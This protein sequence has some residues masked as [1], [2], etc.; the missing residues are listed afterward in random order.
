MRSFTTSLGL[1]LL[2][3]LAATGA[4]AASPTPPLTSGAAAQMLYAQWFVPQSAKARTSAEQLHQQLQQYCAGRSSLEQARAQF[5]QASQDWERLSA[6]AM[7]P[8]IERRTARMV[9]FQP[10]RPQ[11]LQ[12]ALRKAPKNLA[13]METI[14]APAKGFPVAEH[15]LWTDVAQA[16]T[17]ACHYATLVAADL[18]QELRALHQANLAASQFTQLDFD[19]TA[20][21]INQWVGGLERLRWQ[22]MEKPLRSASSSKPAQLTR[23]ASQGTLASW[24]AQ[25]SALRRLT[26]GEG[27]QPEQVS[28]ARLVEVQGWEHLAQEVRE[29]TQKVDS[30]MQAIQAPDLDNITATSKALNQLKHLVENDVAMALDIS[31]G[32]SDADG[33]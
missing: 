5:A 30:A 2:L 27:Q 19:S 4:H 14:G 16:G 3:A 32:F 7:G 26:V 24:Q 22:S 20:E 17:P 28:I 18:A 13:A 31:I 9:D 1:T 21:F 25:W 23:A 10:M 33:D 11:L 12:A 29:A 15:L 8:Q 6:L